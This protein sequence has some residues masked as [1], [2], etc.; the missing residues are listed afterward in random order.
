VQGAAILASFV[1]PNSIDVAQPMTEH[2]E[3]AEPNLLRELLRLFVQS[4][5]SAGSGVA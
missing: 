1:D 3:R 5:M 4:L 2:L